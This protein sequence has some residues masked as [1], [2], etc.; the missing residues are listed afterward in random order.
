[1]HFPAGTI[2]ALA[3][4]PMSALATNRKLSSFLQSSQ[5]K[6]QQP[7]A[8][9]TLLQLPASSTSEALF[10]AAA[11][12]GGGVL[13]A[14]VAVA[15]LSLLVQWAVL[16]RKNTSKA[17]LPKQFSLSDYVG[18][19]SEFVPLNPMSTPSDTDT[20]SMAPLMDS[21]RDTELDDIEQVESHLDFIVPQSDDPSTPAF[22][23]RSVTLGIFWCIVLSFSNCVLS[24]RSVPFIIDGLVAAILAYPLGNLWAA[25][26]YNKLLNPGPF[27]VK[28]HVLIYV[29]AA[30]ATVP[31]G[32][33]N[34]VTQVHPALM[35]N[36]NITFLQSL[37]FVLV[38]QFLGYGF[39]GLTR[40]FLVK[41]TAMW[42]PSLL[43]TIGLFSSFHKTD[44]LKTATSEGTYK[45]S[46]FAFFWIAFACMFIYE[47][48]PQ[49]FAPALQAVSMGCLLAGKGAGS[50]GVLSGFNAVAGSAQTG[51]GLLGLTFDWTSIGAIS[52][53]QPLWANVANSF[54]ILMFIWVATP[55]LIA[56]DTWGLNSLLRTEQDP[57]NPIVNTQH[58]FV[59]NMQN[60]NVGLAVSPLFF[61]NRSDN[62]NLNETAYAIAAPIHVSSMFALE[63]ASAFLTVTSAMTHLALWYGPDIMRQV[64]NAMRQMKD[65]VDGQDKHNKMMEAYPDIP[66]IVYVIFM[67]LATVAALVVSLVTPFNMPWW[68]IFFNLFLVG[69]FVVPYG[70]IYAITGTQLFLN[71]LSEFVIGMIIPGQTVAVNCF[72]SWGTNNLAQALRLSAD[73]KLGLYLHIPPYAIVG[74]QFIGTFVSSIVGTIAAYFVMFNS[75]NLLGSTGWTYNGYQTFYSAGA[76]WGAIGP[77][78]FFGIGSLYQN[79]LWCFLI[80]AIAPVFPWLGNKYIYKSKV[81]HYIN[82]PIIFSFGNTGAPQVLLVMTFVVGLISQVYLFNRRRA[83][84]E[85]YL[86]V[87]ASAFDAA[88]GVVN[89]VV[90]LMTVGGVSFTVMHALNPSSNVPVDYYCYPGASFVDFDCGYYVA[91]GKNQTASGQQCF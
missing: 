8:A 76:I 13:G 90:S 70:V 9:K 84:Y 46:R 85:K 52:L 14:T 56:S 73:L 50:S 37:S 21:E 60:P 16:R 2:A 42:W 7:H 51:V 72:K 74:A 68:A 22:T 45:I 88:G 61:Y 69:L 25:L 83:F 3:V 10:K 55:L 34:V 20:H 89:V 24:F 48:I 5:S 79:L 77:S 71:V 31:Y 30:T 41:P 86:Y 54:G 28:E 67:G 11:A 78:R 23:V 47:W 43:P 80:G 40:R 17:N 62:Y 39:A 59:G 44:S 49:F 58:L 6:L 63:Y 33:D 27:T 12:T 75:G 35:N 32:I 81:W 19:S 57:L 29:M 66:D 87:M 1:M 36:T 53:V 15:V 65:E 26:P 18:A 91:I 64:K 38:T 4:I 82:F